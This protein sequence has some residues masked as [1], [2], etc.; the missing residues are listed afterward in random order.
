MYSRKF[1]G[2]GRPAAERPRD[3][4][5]A[6]DAAV[7]R[8]LARTV[9]AVLAHDAEAAAVT[10]GAAARLDVQR[11]ALDEHREAAL[12]DLDGEV[13]GVAVGRRD[14]RGGAVAERAAAPAADVRLGEH[15]QLAG[16][17]GADDVGAA[18]ARVAA[19]A[20][21]LGDDGRERLPDQVVRERRALVVPARR[22]GRLRAEDRFRAAP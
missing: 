1:G 6:A 5:E 10:P 4:P 17:V 13:V 20:E 18:E 19:G 21:P 7:A 11:V 2:A 12:D 22:G 3:A 14:Q 16:L 8:G 15:E 9:D